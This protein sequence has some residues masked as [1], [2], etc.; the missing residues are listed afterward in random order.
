MSASSTR[1]YE[2]STVLEL[3]VRGKHGQAGFVLAGRTCVRSDAGG[4]WNEWT[5][6]FDDGRQGFLAEA[7][8]TFTLF[9]ERPIA[10]PFDAL[11]IGSALKTGFVVVERG[12][13]KRV[14]RWGDVPEAPR[15]YRYADL[16][17]ASGESATI[18]YGERASEPDVFVGRRMKLAELGLRPRAERPRFLPAPGGPTPKGVELWLA[19]GD[20]GELPTSSGGKARF[21]VIGIVH[22]SIRVEGE[23]YAW[24]EYVLHA[25]AEGLRWLVVGDGHWNLVET[26]EAGQVEE[27]EEKSAKLGGETYRFLSSGKA[28]IEWATGELPWEVAVGDLTEARDYVRA[29][30]M[31]S[32]ESSEDEVT[33]SLGTY[34]P[35][36]V[37]S[38]A[39]G[40][41]LLPKPTGRAANEPRT[42]KRR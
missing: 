5:L 8:G 19:V 41:R 9:F 24:E 22:R 23:R 3:G 14:A 18:D 42:P 30:H 7:L 21:R 39:F 27:T 13:A 29:P 28:R 35:P 17:S 12:R 4:L 2:A 10:P 40:K 37:I 16:S 38:R 15:T 1:T 33:W 25:P 11:V 31:L 34:T 20:E 26:L 36:G 32:R 6:A